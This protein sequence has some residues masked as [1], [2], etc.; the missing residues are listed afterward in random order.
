MFNGIVI[1]QHQ[2]PLWINDLK[3]GFLYTEALFLALNITY[4]I[5]AYPSLFCW[6]RSISKQNQH[7]N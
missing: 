2:W 6:I 3:K 7:G 5:T 4:D 1:G